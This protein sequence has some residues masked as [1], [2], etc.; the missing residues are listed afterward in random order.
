MEQ[1]GREP[2]P[3]QAGP[4]GSSKDADPPPSTT[5]E[6]S[7]TRRTQRSCTPQ[8][9]PST[10]PTASRNPSR[11]PSTSRRSLKRTTFSPVPEESHASHTALAISSSTPPPEPASKKPRSASRTTSG[12]PKAARRGQR[13]FGVLTST[14]TQFKRDSESDRAAT[15]A[16]RRAQIEARSASKLALSSHQIDASLLHRS[17]L[18]EARSLSEQIVTG[19]IQ[20]KTL[21]GLKRRMASFLYTP[22]TCREREDRL[23]ANI[24][25]SSTGGGRRADEEGDFAVYFLPG[26]TLPEQE[27]KLNDQ[28]DSV[29]DKIDRFDDR[30]EEERR[31]LLQR[32]EDVKAKIREI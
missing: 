24:P 32:L 8:S 29:D 31:R 4:S 19:D 6:A 11:S 1:H 22:T 30:W 28:E 18:W 2:A 16:Q 3:A 20:R 13:L 14:L 7:P 25:T 17:L 12:D 10:S 21:R 27:D 9:L 15:L 5:V 23:A 26:K